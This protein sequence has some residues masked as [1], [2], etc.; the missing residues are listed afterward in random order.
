MA[1]CHRNLSRRFQKLEQELIDALPATTD[2][3]AFQKERLEIEKD[4]PPIYRALDLLCH[5][6]ACKAL[7][8]DHTIAID[9]YK[10]WTAQW[11]R[12]TSITDSQTS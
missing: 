3:R 11:L 12:W 5:Y 9:G 7:G 4:E 2:L 1:D 8:C 6:E 10:R